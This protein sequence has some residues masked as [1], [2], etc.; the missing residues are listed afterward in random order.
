MKNKKERKFHNKKKK[1]FAS[2]IM[3]MRVRHFGLNSRICSKLSLKKR[4]KEKKIG[5][6][7]FFWAKITF[8]CLFCLFS[9][10][11]SNRLGKSSSSFLDVTEITPYL[12]LCGALALRSNVL[13]DLKVTCVINATTELPDT[14]LPKSSPDDDD[15]D[16][17]ILY[18]RVNVDDKIDA[19][20][21]PW[22]DIVSDIIHQVDQSISF[23][24]ADGKLLLL[25]LL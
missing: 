11:C 5:N 3:M 18:L 22:L 16:D 7:N 8:F 15:N 4:R 19:N 25:L 14:P 23:I 20:I 17:D 10:M 13:E 6:F 1:F 9:C 12:F 21:F 2:T 24:F